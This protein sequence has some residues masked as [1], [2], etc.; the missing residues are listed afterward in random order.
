MLDQHYQALVRKA[1]EVLG[2]GFAIAVVGWRD[3]NHNQF[4]RQLSDSKVVFL[5]S[6]PSNLTEKVG[7]VFLTRFVHHADV[8]RIRKHHNVHP[9]VLDTGQIK[10]VLE[11]CG[12]LLAPAPRRPTV[13]GVPREVTAEPAPDA[14]G[15]DE[16]VLDFLTT[17]FPKEAVMSAMDC[18]TRAFLAAAEANTLRPG[19]VG[20][21]VLGKIRRD[22]GVGESPRQMV[23]DGWLKP[24]VSEG[25]EHAG[26][27]KAG[28]RML[29]TSTDPKF[30]PADPI[31]RA[32]FL[33]AR[34]DAIL[35]EQAELEGK[36]EQVK[37]QLERIRTAEKLLGQLAELMGPS[38]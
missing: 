17:P 1:R 33:I 30:E 21:K 32:R 18:F 19:S 28:E 10:R 26:W 22:C 3:S 15:V 36:L 23:S 9:V 2:S 11:S 31:E 4:T 20:K 34:K 38:E 12:D 25:R 14:R 6:S 13:A 16:D 37:Q 35:A 24:D 27:Y 8:E 29:S 5:D 7:L